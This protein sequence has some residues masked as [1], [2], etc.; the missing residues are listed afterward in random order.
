MPHIFVRFSPVAPKLCRRYFST[1]HCVSCRVVLVIVL[2]TSSHFLSV[3]VSVCE[4]ERE[5][6][7]TVLVSPMGINGGDLPNCSMTL[8]DFSIQAYT[9]VWPHKHFNLVKIWLVLLI[10]WLVLL[11][12]FST[13]FKGFIVLSMFYVNF[14]YL[15]WTK[16]T[17]IY[18]IERSFQ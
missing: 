7:I 6:E 3:T 13:K 12:M 11:I 8:W 1:I 17:L 4:R 18:Y 9:P 10:I 2:I 16:I 14:S 5:R 15:F